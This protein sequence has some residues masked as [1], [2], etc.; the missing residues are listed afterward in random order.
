MNK[1][2]TVLLAAILS[3]LFCGSSYAKNISTLATP[4][5]PSG[6]K[7]YGETAAGAAGYLLNSSICNTASSLGFQLD[8]TDETTKMNTV[9]ADF[10][11]ANGGCLAIDAGKTLRVDG[12]IVFPHDAEYPWHQPV[13]RI[14]G[15]SAGG[16]QSAALN[17][18]NADVSGGVDL[19][20]GGYYVTFM[21]DSGSVLDVRYQGSGI[22]L[23]QGGPKI[24]TT[25]T[26]KLY[27]DH[28]TL[29]TGSTSEDPA[30]FIMTT[31]TVLFAHDLSIIGWRQEGGSVGLN[32]AFIL[33]G[34]GTISVPLTGTIADRFGGY[35]SQIFNNHFSRLRHLVMTGQSVANNLNI[36]GNMNDT[37]CGSEVNGGIAYWLRSGD[38][39]SVHDNIIE[40]TYYTY[41]IWAEGSNNSF[42]NS[43][44]W[45]S[46]STAYAYCSGTSSD[47]NYI[48]DLMSADTRI[49]PEMYDPS[50]NNIILTKT[51]LR[52]PR[53]VFPDGTALTSV[54]PDTTAP[55]LVSAEVPVGMANKLVITL[56]SDV[57]M[58]V[59]GSA[60]V[61]LTMTGGAVTASY[62]SGDG[63]SILTYTLS[64]A[65]SYGE[66]GTVAYT[67]PTQ[68]ITD[69]SANELATFADEAVTNNAALITNVYLNYLAGVD[70]NTGLDS[71]HPVATIAQA[72]TI[73]PNAILNIYYPDG[74]YHA[75]PADT[76]WA[77]LLAYYPMTEGSG[78]SV[79]D[80]AN[81]GQSI[82]L[83]LGGGIDPTWDGSTPTKGL[84]FDGTKYM[85]QLSTFYNI[86]QPVSYIFAHT[87][88]AGYAGSPTLIDGYEASTQYRNIVQMNPSLQHILY[89]GTNQTDTGTTSTIGSP[90]MFSTIFN[91]ANSTAYK[92]ATQGYSGGVVD[93]GAYQ[94]LTHGFYIGRAQSTSRYSGVI[95]AFLMY[96][97]ALDST[98]IANVHSWMQT[99]MSTVHGVT[100]P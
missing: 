53:I 10:Y 61:S 98:D 57:R 31:N 26:G 18:S 7:Y 52:A 46:Q 56:D 24:L 73:A 92:G 8:G 1:T 82:T 21:E 20:C 96:G 99:E 5:S 86:T 71:T 59:G 68:G 38:A 27:L 11:T 23:Y 76:K 70:T 51:G 87:L 85:Q 74:T 3:I 44:F 50:H 2:G 78:T 81:K 13:Y 30:A 29:K 100:I 32:D 6:A 63:S 55:S 9:L 66:T 67:Q 80:I 39:S 35:G 12:Q 28:F 37:T 22:S 93:S 17:C 41:G 25:G 43:N 88:A 58:G 42:I 4:I 33:G 77:S 49:C 40:G 90:E 54:I 89:A 64:R 97:D 79:Y 75:M 91:G 47:N 62:L 65:I 95:S 34:E 83:N 84:T 36:Y 14:T 48:V 16:G 19:T 45:D 15:S 60:G 72:A 69:L 94:I